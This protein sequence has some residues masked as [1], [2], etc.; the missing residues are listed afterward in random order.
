VR[1][2][3]L[4]E[5]RRF[6]LVETDV[7]K[8]T[9]PD[10]VLVRV[11]RAVICGSDRPYFVGDAGQYPAAIGH[12]IHECVGTVEESTSPRFRP[13]DRVLAVPDGQRGLMECFA[14]PAE[15][16]VRLP[17]GR[18]SN[19]IVLA[20]PLG[21][22]LWA[23]RKLGNLI[24]ADTVVL[25]QGPMGL[26]MDAMLSNLGAKTV[27]GVDR[28]PER[29]AVAQQMRATHI[30]DATAEDVPARVR[31]ITD[32]RMADLVVEAVGHQTQT[33]NE[34]LR[35]VRNGGTVLAFGVP[36]DE[37]YPF[38]F[39]DFY[40]RNLTMVGSVVPEAQRDYPLAMDMILQGRVDVRPLLTHELP[41]SE[42]Q[43]AFELFCDRKEGAIKVVLRYDAS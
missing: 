5:P 7:P 18:F 37:V 14:A 25:G 1:A 24:H 43:R 33:M 32:G 34:C 4:V 30:L 27:I 35:L 2:A 17:D 13:G 22:V 16:V 21:T 6:E 31:D 38:R 11:N 12:S 39:K 15:R 29:L 20:Q 19:E 10:T 8:L 42:V 36:D 3:R 26:L 23:L 41:F 28:I 40:F 9:A